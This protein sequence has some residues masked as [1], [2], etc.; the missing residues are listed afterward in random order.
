[1]NDIKKEMVTIRVG[2]LGFGTVGQGTWKHLVENSD[3][4]SKILGVRLVPTH[5]SVRSLSKERDVKISNSQLT[6]DSQSIVDNPD[7]DLI[8]E[9]IGGIDEAL[10]LTLRAFSKGKSVITANKALICEHGEELFKAAEDAGV[11]YAFE[12]SVAGGIPII[13]VLRESLVANEFPLIY[14]ILNGTSNYILTRMEKEGTS[15]E[16]VLGDARKLGYVEADESLDLDGVDAAHKA[17]ILAYLAH[18]LWVKLKDITVEGIS[19]ISNQDLEAALKLGCKIKLIGVIRRNFKNNHV[20]VGVFPAL[21]PIDEIIARTDGVF[22]GVSLTG[23]VVGTV[24]LTGRG[25]GQD[26]TAGSVISDLV[27]VVKSMH[28]LRN[29]V[30]LLHVAPEECSPASAVEIKGRYYL[31]LSVDDKPGQLA[32]VA[33]CLSEHEVS[34][35]T[36]S[37][38]PKGE[39][40]LAS[41]IL[42]TH[43]TNEESMSRAIESLENLTGV[44]E[45]P[46]LFR[47]FDPLKS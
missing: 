23:S 29:A 4:W 9:L 37:Q 6:T 42:T 28:G 8:C 36:V 26:P 13:K 41:L 43:E 35:E 15:F 22:N 39:N 44:C 20:S 47:I 5:A 27:D 19:K 11:H 24:V 7:V 33:E 32:K 34:L 16:E 18:G 17:V 1:M 40:S 31:R 21:V 3:F 2:I 10:E 46:V 12:A 25:A 38:K 14:G 45:S 30:K